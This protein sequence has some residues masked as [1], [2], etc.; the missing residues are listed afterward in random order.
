MEIFPDAL[1]TFLHLAEERSFGEVARHLGISQSTV[2]AHVRALEAA[3]DETLLERRRGPGGGTELTP[4]GQ[5][6]VVVARDL[7]DAHER[8]RARFSKLRDGGTVRLAIADDIAALDGVGDAIRTFRRR[9]P[10]V[11]VEITVGQS[12]NLARRLRAGQFDLALIKR[13]AGAEG[14]AIIRRERVVW[15][16]HAQTRRHPG[17]PLPLV[18]YPSYSFLRQRSSDRLDEEGVPWRIANTVRGVNGAIAAVR[19]ELGIGVFAEGLLPPD[20]RPAPP[21]W[22]LPDL[23]EVDTVVAR[24]VVL[25]PSA[26]AL[27]STLEAWGP[28]LLRRS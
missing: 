28:D 24:A 12:S 21:E 27:L 1:A 3:V 23:G 5:E 13:P 17:L 7:L 2:S 16:V 9:Q 20:L 8:A 6:F 18:A 11:S 4:S 10:A 15:A 19:A 26:E 14:V 22:Q 25:S